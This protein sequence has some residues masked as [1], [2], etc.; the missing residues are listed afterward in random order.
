[1]RI[2]FINAITLCCLLAPQL[3]F[4][5]GEQTEL[6]MTP[7]A[8]KIYDHAPKTPEQLLTLIKEFMD[9]P[10]MNGYEFV[11]KVSGIDREHWGDARISETSKGGK[12]NLY[13]PLRRGN[14]YNQQETDKRKL[15]T[16]YFVSDIRF[17]SGDNVLL[18]HLRVNF[19]LDIG[20]LSSVALQIT[21]TIAQNI[22]GE[23]TKIK[24][25]SARSEYSPGFYNLSY[26]YNIGKY[27]LGISFREKDDENHELQK[28]FWS[29]TAEQAQKEITRRKQFANHKDFIARG[30][31]LSLQR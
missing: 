4:A 27:E 17:S 21:P 8:Q 20:P 5:G 11:E 23:P 10:D 29:H 6:V 24:V 31:G 2:I 12:F 19:R 13:S 22:F 9:N 15:P 18:S 1:M 14:P 7:R 25:S 16:T 30:L 3:L 28:L 26:F